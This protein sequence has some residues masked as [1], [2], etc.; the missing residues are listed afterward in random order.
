MYYICMLP[1]SSLISLVENSSDFTGISTLDGKVLYL[2]KAGL[3]LVGLKNIEEAK[4]KHILDFVSPEVKK[5]LEAGVLPKTRK[6]GSARGVNKLRH[7]QTGKEID[8]EF[9]LFLLRAPDTGEPTNL[10]VI[11]RDISEQKKTESRLR[12]ERNRAQRYLDIAEVMLVALDS[13]G[14]IELINRKGCRILGY[15]EKELVGKNW[16]DTCLPPAL[17]ETVKGVFHQ[18]ITGDLE[19]VEYYENPVITKSGEERLVAWHNTYISDDENNITGILS[20]GEDITERK[21][22]EEKLKDSLQEKEILIKEIHHRVKNNMAVISSLLNLQA[23]T[24]DH[25]LVKHA[26]RESRNRIHSMALVHEKLYQ[27]KNLSQIDF[28]NYLESLSR[29]IINSYAGTSSPVSLQ[30]NLEP[31]SLEIDLAIPCGLIVN[32]LVTNSL[33][34]AFPDKRQGV[35]TMELRYRENHTLELTVGDNGVGLPSE[36]DIENTQ[37][38]GLQLVH[39]LAS[40]IEADIEYKRNPGTSFKITFNYR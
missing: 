1:E 37:T 32:E 27:S 18:L 17:R 35:I 15:E 14:N 5:Y 30:L 2:N 40:Q 3:Q 39:M 24:V 19:P 28:K 10:A 4:S 36:M 9:N 20:S 21:L 31:A 38:L 6:Y 7:F 34:Y 29:Q 33:K 25:P 23:Q 11:L 12:D 13:S 8:V 26:F 22:G 16:F